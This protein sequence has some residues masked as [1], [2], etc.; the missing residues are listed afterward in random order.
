M[1]DATPAELAITGFLSEH[2]EYAILYSWE[3]NVVYI[4]PNPNTSI[5]HFNIQTNAMCNDMEIVHVKNVQMQ[6]K[7]VERS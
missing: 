4:I 1:C 6:C 3:Q 7:I 2:D 5:N